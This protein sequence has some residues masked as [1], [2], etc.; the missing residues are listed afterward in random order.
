MPLR[1]IHASATTGDL[2][3]SVADAIAS[4][5]GWA[6]RQRQYATVAFSGGRTPWV[7]LAA[8]ARHPLAWEHVHI[9]QV[10]ERAAP[11]G[12]ADRN[13]AQLINALAPAQLP[14]SNVHAIQIG[15]DLDEAALNYEQAVGAHAP[16]GFDV[17][18]LGLGADG[19]TASL[20]PNDPV[21]DVDD[22]NVA[23]T[24]V[25]QGWPRITLTYPALNAARSIVWMVDG[26]AKAAALVLLRSRDPSIPAGRVDT[27]NAQIFCDHAAAAT[28][29]A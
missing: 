22:R 24:G 28:G 7:M 16:N 12:H 13:I 10:D 9:F 23:V 25:Y 26:A 3:R 27:T 15:P 19:H 2:A 8:L 21:L 18:H 11:D 6:V 4:E 5:I 14:P 17:V 20:I 29:D 1:P